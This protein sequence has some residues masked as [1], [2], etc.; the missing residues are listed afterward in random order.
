MDVWIEVKDSSYRAGGR[1]AVE[2]SE[3]AQAELSLE[4][5]C[6]WLLGAFTDAL[7]DDVL[8]SEHTH[9]APLTAHVEHV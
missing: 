7:V 6:C 4:G 2:M 5:C 1:H 3:P 8:L 9:E